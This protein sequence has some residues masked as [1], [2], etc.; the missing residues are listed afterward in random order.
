MSG[1]E[2]NETS[3]IDIDS[4]VES[5]TN[6][7][8]QSASPPQDD[9]GESGEIVEAKSAEPSSNNTVSSVDDN[10]HVPKTWPKEMHQHWESTPKEVQK[11][12]REREEQMMSGLEKY[13]NNALYG[14]SIRKVLDPYSR[15]LSAANINE[16]DIVGRLMN[17]HWRLTQGLDSDRRAAYEELGRNLGFI[18]DAKD[19]NTNASGTPEVMQALDRISRIENT[20]SAENTL[21]LEQA[22]NTATKEVEAFASDTKS[23]PHFDEVADDIVRFINAGETLD[24]AYDSAIWKNKVTRAKEIA[25]VQTD[26]EAKFK[27]NARLDALPKKKAAGVNI[28]SRDTNVALTEPLGSMDDTL[29]HTL[30]S[31]RER[32]TN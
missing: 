7:L 21:R 1:N 32:T 8:F 16:A 3:T 2:S 4:A 29:K 14:E 9:N 20:L 23:H 18:Q 5:I 25:R 24:E 12:W 15:H 10:S 26:H 17:A 27:E 11:Y 30:R 6:D 19:S 22:R 31:I 13:R 28:K